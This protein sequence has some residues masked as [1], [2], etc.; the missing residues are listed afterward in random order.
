MSGCRAEARAARVAAIFTPYHD[1][2]A[3]L[4]DARAGRRTVLV[5][6]HSFTP[7]F[8][9]ESRAMHVGMLYNKDAAPGADP[10]GPAAAGG[11]PGRRRQRALRGDRGQRLR[12]SDAWREAR[13]GA[14]RDRD[15]PG[16]D[17]QPEGQEAWAQRFARLLTA[18]D[19]ALKAPSRPDGSRARG[20]L[21]RPPPAD[22][23]KT[24]LMTRAE[25]RGFIEALATHNPAPETELSFSD[26]FTVAGR[27]GAVGPGDRSV[28]QPGHGTL[29]QAAPTPKA[30][31]A[32][33]V[34]GVASHIRSIGLWQTKA[35]NVVAPVAG[36][37]GEAR[38][39]RCRRDRAALEALPGVGRKTANVVLNVAFGES[40]MAVDTHIFRLGNRTGLAPGKT[41]REVEDG[42]LKRIPP[43]RLRDCAPLADPARPL[44][45]QGAPAGVLALRR[46][47]MVPLRRQ[48]AS[49]NGGGLKRCQRARHR[50][51]HVV[52]HPRLRLG[53][54]PHRRIPR[55]IGSLRHPA[56]AAV[57]P[58]QHPDRSSQR[59]G[60][61]RHRGINTDHQVQR[62]DQRR[63]VGEIA[64]VHRSSRPPATPPP[65]ARPRP[66][67][68]TRT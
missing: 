4:L 39:R 13:A 61:V 44:C 47:G 35:R 25:V 17:R 67:A 5:A 14:C 38:R 15:P 49:P 1:R 58:V 65:G 30:M 27:G 12:R 28:G 23:R 63:G 66:S 51:D 29:F 8:K 43:E 32:L 36:A 9:G 60:R 34:D 55:G 42:L 6:M 24:P 20:R 50:I 7:S 53:E 19:A 16:P 37:G 41:P 22:R 3:R 56:P 46:R 64:P 21:P 10:A 45:L 31:V 48:T 68:A 62:L 2:I 54:Q 33:G 18:A 59:T 40:T 52:P 11:R 26:P 57:E